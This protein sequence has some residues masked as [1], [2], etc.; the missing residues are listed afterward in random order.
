MNGPSLYQEVQGF[1]PW[2]YAL[3]AVVLAIL[4]A[5]A[6]LRMTTVV[7]AD[8][9]TVRFGFLYTARVPLKD[10]VRAEAIV[11]RPVRDYGGWGIKGFRNRRALNARGD[12]GVLLVRADGSTLLVGSQRPQEL[13]TALAHAGVAT[14]NRLPAD[15]REF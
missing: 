3:L 9:V 4:L 12:R 5:V 2:T 15:L 8:A 14:E 7:T 10:L 6:S 1:A 11:Y 13:L